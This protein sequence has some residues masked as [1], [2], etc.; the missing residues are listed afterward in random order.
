MK[1]GRNKIFFTREERNLEKNILL[2]KGQS[3]YDAMKIYIDELAK[4]FRKYGYNTLVLDGEWKGMVEKFYKAQDEYKFAF[5]MTCNGVLF[6]SPLKID[7]IPWLTYLCD[8]PSDHYSRIMNAKSND[9]I[10]TCDQ[11]HKKY[12]EKYYKNIKNV[13]FVPLS[14]SYVKEQKEWNKRSIDLIFT[15]SYSNPKELKKRILNK[16]DGVILAFVEYIIKDIENNPEYTIEEYLERALEYYKVKNETDKEEFDRLLKE[17][18]YLNTYAR[19][20]YRDKIIRTI[21]EANIKIHVSGDGWDDFESDKKHNLK[22]LKGGN[23][24]ARKAVA[25]AKIS[26]NIMPWFK[27]GFQERIATAMLSGAIAL[28]DSSK[29]IEENFKNGEELV[30]YSLKNIEDLPQIIINLL[31]NPENSSNI[32]N[33]GKLI[34][35]KEHKW[36]DRARNIIEAFEGHDTI[37]V[38]SNTGQ[39]LQLKIEESVE[40]KISNITSELEKI[41]DWCNSIETFSMFTKED[42]LYAYKWI[43]KINADID[44]PDYILKTKDIFL[45]DDNKYDTLFLQMVGKGLKFYVENFKNQILKTDNE[46]ENQILRNMNFQLR[47]EKNEIEAKNNKIV[48]ERII[49]N[50][51]DNTDIEIQA[52]IN[53]I[54]STKTIGAYN[55]EYL[56]KYINIEIDRLIDI[57]FDETCDMYYVNFQDKR[58]YYPK[59]YSREQALYN[60]RFILIEQDEKSPHCYMDENF[61]VKEDDVAI[62]A[63][64]AEGNFALSII[65]KVKKLYL[66]ECEKDW[67]EALNKT[68][69]PYKEKVVIV[70]KYLGAINDETH[71]TIDA[72]VGEDEE[73]NFIKMDIEGEEENALI[74][75]RRVLED[76]SNIKCAICAYHRKNA[77]VRISRYLEELQF[78][79]TTTKGYMFFREDIDSLIDG[80]LRKGIIRA[81][82]TEEK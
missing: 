36:S 45:L 40:Q 8:H 22:V 6:D 69:E 41:I 68:F 33:G 19:L 79:V 34:A 21:I 3:K 47:K 15:G 27:Y 16:Y 14:G 43:E 11:F 18:F 28:T 80:E 60:T 50:Y 78:K 51:Q 30:I 13:Y 67:V 58:M 65:D 62:D 4:G 29:Y 54:K 23:Y 53:R 55:Y 77:D 31:K 56:D 66:I 74:G 72:L 49:R 75:A 5:I 63:G 70:E 42:I 25:N 26:L 48:V 2:I 73:I 57:R 24:L 82:K 61:M 20:Y 10:F 17:L 9:I 46:I 76:N 64:V 39:E 32:A 44:S 37:I 35:Q 52:I 12:I 7:G 59:T 1:E 71:I 38:E 81:W